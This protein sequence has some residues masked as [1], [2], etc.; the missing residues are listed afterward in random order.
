M[1]IWN[2]NSLGSASPYRSAVGLVPG[3]CVG[4]AE[5]G[6][7]INSYLATEP[8]LLMEAGPHGHLP[9]QVCF[10]VA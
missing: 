9:V 6:T 2:R 3:R 8:D 1:E 10:P 7:D 5:P 4:R